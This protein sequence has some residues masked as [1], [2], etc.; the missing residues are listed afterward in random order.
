MEKLKYLIKLKYRTFFRAISLATLFA[1]VATIVITPAAAY[2]DTTRA[3]VD[4]DPRKGP[5]GTKVIVIL[6]NF[7]AG[8]VDISFDAESNIVETCSTDDDGNAYSYFIA[9][10]YPAGEYKVWAKDGTNREYSVFTITPEI[11]LDK[12]T[13]Y[14]DDKVVVTGTGFAAKSEVSVLFDGTEVTI[15]KTDEDGCFTGATFKI[16]ESSNGI[17]TVKAIDSDKNYTDASFSTEQSVTISSQKEGVGNGV[18]ISGTGF[19]AD[20]DI[21]ITLANEKVAKGKSDENG[22]F[23]TTFIVPAIVKGSYRIKIGDGINNSYIDFSIQAGT[24]LNPTEG[25]VGT[26]LTV[27]G[28]GFTANSKVTIKYDNTTATTAKTNANGKFEVSFNVPVSKKGEH[29]I[30]ATD[31]TTTSKMTF[32]ME[33]EA[34]P[35]PK[36]LLPV[37]GTKVSET[38]TFG[39]ERVTDPSGVSY[40]FQVATDE[41]FSNLVLEKSGLTDPEYNVTAGESLKPVKKETPYYWRV[42]AIDRADNNGK[43]S[44]KGSFYMGLTIAAPPGWVQWGLTGLGIT[45][46]GFLFGTFLNR[47]RR[48][49]LGD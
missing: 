48:L 17:H 1:L 25:N 8:T 32:T 29:T 37:S 9:E 22:S 33:S 41:N 30:T 7:V 46:F 10:E 39:W 4:L 18:T 26:E 45:L 6:T 13:G 19:A 34:P 3:V 47:L 12:T 24:S 14:V 21:I 28:S 49:T 5:V 38:P 27:S 2:G 16:P 20:K 11:E 40:T 31:S 15:D 42:R 35:A 43:W 44:G 23:S 36:L